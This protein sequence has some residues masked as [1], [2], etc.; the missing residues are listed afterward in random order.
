MIMKKTLLLFTALGIGLFSVAQNKMIKPIT[1]STK[2]VKVNNKTKIFSGDEVMMPLNQS[3]H[4]LKNH[5]KNTNINLGT[6]IGGTTYDLQ[7]N[8]STDNHRIYKYNDGTIA[9]LWTFSNTFDLAASDR[10][11]GYNY[12]NGTSWGALPTARL[13]GSRTGWPTMA[14]VGNNEFVISHAVTPGISFVAYQSPKGGTSWAAANTPTSVSQPILWPR[15]ASSGP[16]TQ[17]LYAIGLTLPTG[18]GGAV[19]NGL[20][21]AIVFTRSLDGG[22]T[23]DALTQ[24]PGTE[25]TDGYYG[26]SGDGYAI[27]AK[28]DT[29]VIAVFGDWF[30]TFIL[31]SVD[32]G[33]TF[34]KTIVWQFP[35]PNYNYIADTQISDVNGD[36]IA[37]TIQGT[38]QSGAV[39]ID[40]SGNAHLFMGY[41][42][43]MNDATGDGS[44]S[45][46]PGTDG[47]IYWREGM[48]SIDNGGGYV[49]TS[50][51]DVDNS[52]TI[53]VT[54]FGVY[55]FSLSS[56]ANAG[57]DAAGNIYLVYS[58]VVENTDYGDGRS[59][60]NLYAMKH[61]FGANDSV[62]SAP[63]NINQDDVTESVFAS[64]A[65]NVDGYIH[66]VFQNDPEPGLVVRGP[67]PNPNTTYTENDIRY[68]GFDVNLLLGVNEISET[69]LFEV[70]QNYPNP[71]SSNSV[72]DVKLNKPSELSLE[73]SNMLGQQIVNYNA[74]NC[75]AGKH[76]MVI[77]AN[78]LT[79]G[80]YFYTVKA[81]EIKVTKKMIVE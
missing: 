47:I 54:D 70:S 61:T 9:G 18:N 48:P 77:D 75:A 65:K 74:G 32:A 81:G 72:I 69:N 22:T 41:M 23:W 31:K 44:S 46:F 40:N 12:Y 1:Y 80:I 10:G 26:F 24:I 50:M 11:S 71:F 15:L 38:D 39:I 13:E 52:G 33:A 66:I 5:P 37:D 28:G 17:K 21:G 29:V 19:Y 60:R 6:K 7:T 64:V 43:V 36:A 59:L 2:S 30:D 58:S 56:M 42:R 68:L 76:Q 8:G 34:T 57:I 51:V 14:P 73:I 55:Y 53:D 45:Y 20:D 25:S 79:A 78:K 16:G 67:N 4:L 3:T 49:I 63:Y 35:I 62:W 27:D